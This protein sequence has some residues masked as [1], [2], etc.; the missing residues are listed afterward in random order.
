MDATYYDFSSMDLDV[1]YHENNP[2]ISGYPPSPEDSPLF[3]SPDTHFFDE[4]EAAVMGLKL[5]YHS[6]GSPASANSSTSDDL[7]VTPL[8]CGAEAES[9][10]QME[11]ELETGQTVFNTSNICLELLHQLEQSESRGMLER[12]TSVQR[13]QTSTSGAAVNPA[14][15]IQNSKKDESSRRPADE[16]QSP[17]CQKGAINAPSLPVKSISQPRAAVMEAA[18][19]T[20]STVRQDTNNFSVA[21]INVTKVGVKRKAA[22]GKV[23]AKRAKKGCEDSIPISRNEKNAIAARENR[24]KKKVEFEELKRN[25]TLLQEE[26]ESLRKENSDYVK[27]IKVLE[28]EVEYYKSVL[29]NESALA[30]ILH[31][32]NPQS[33]LKLS[34]SV[35]VSDQEEMDEVKKIMSGGVCLHVNGTDTSLEWCSKCSMNAQKSFQ[36]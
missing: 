35:G 26:N 10:C 23:E 14:D 4:D 16:E 36:S 25:G 20:S 13:K 18:A 9:Y 1:F 33:K 7:P 17:T 27:K 19:S 34:S 2:A 30:T 29:F 32:I 8:S 28:Q 24:L 31:K 6:C 5:S 12:Q 11:K 3:E 22:Q 15:V 21:K